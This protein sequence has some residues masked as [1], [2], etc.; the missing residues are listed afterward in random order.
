MMKGTRSH[1]LRL[2]G[3][4]VLLGTVAVIWTVASGQWSQGAKVASKPAKEVAAQKGDPS[5]I[6]MT[7]ETM[8]ASGISLAT[9]GPA[10]IRETITLYGSIKPDRE[11]EQDVRARYAGTVRSV[12][13]QQ[14]DAVR[15]QEP[16]LTVESS[17]SLQTYTIDSALTGTV[18]DRSVN[19]GATID[20]STVLMRI[21]DLS[22]VWAEFAVFPQDFGRV[23]KGAT[24]FV[25]GSD[26][27]PSTTATISYVAPAG[28][29]ND[30]SIVVRAI[31]DNAQER[32]VPGEFVT[33][34]VVVSA[35]KAQIAIQPAALQ[36]LDG[37]DVAFV[38]TG[39][40]FET[41][42]VKVGERS[43]SAVAIVSGLKAGEHYAAANS[44]RIL[45]EITKGSADED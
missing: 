38:W 13:K 33:A 27:K 7:A 24:V 12:L 1:V 11:R 30:Q 44:Y 43:D 2:V 39:K 21:A 20:A 29:S 19:P 32:W 3:A 25:T 34:K 36:S 4:L 8:R 10:E 14:G 45:A 5:F 37:R 9:A 41:R 17:E 15:F 31:L 35:A 6:P 22:S 23:R 16:L 28:N 42:Y 18:L 26:G 40:G